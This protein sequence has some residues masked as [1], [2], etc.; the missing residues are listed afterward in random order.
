MTVKE[1][2]AIGPVHCL[3]DCNPSCDVTWKLK[4]ISGLS[5]LS[6][7]EGMLLPLVV[8]R[9][10]EMFRCEAQWRIKNEIL[11]K[12]IGLDVQCKYLVFFIIG[13]LPS[14]QLLYFYFVFNYI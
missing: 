13:F 6:S 14:F 1:G 10:M 8:N 3:A 9:S 5:D 7:K 12:S 2:T 4:T 11:N